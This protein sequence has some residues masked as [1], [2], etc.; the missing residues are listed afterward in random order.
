MS[1]GKS[2]KEVSKKDYFIFTFELFAIFNV[3]LQLRSTLNRILFNTTELFTEI[4]PYRIHYEY[5][6]S[7]QVG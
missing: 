3:Q 4:I 1:L 2:R 6:A 5:E 7:T